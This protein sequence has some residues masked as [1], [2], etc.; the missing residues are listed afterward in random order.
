MMLLQNENGPTAVESAVRL[1]LILVMSSTD[2]TTLGANA[3]KTF[4]SVGSRIESAAS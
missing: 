1:A 3:N 4:S 2:I